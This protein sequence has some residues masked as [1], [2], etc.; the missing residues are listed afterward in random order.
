MA[1]ERGK[2]HHFIFDNQALFSHR[3]MA[4]ILGV[5]IKLPPIKQALAREQVK[6]RYLEYLISKSKYR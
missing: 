4:A 6:S 2:L 3:M 5:I 1:I